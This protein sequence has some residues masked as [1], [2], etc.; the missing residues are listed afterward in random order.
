LDARQYHLSLDTGV[1]GLDKAEDIIIKTL[2][3]RF[4]DV[5]P[6]SQK[7]TATGS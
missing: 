3:A 7:I 6:R 2:Q 4:S 1:L 5:K